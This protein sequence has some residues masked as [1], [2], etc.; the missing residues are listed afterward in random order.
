MLVL[1]SKIK[2]DDTTIPFV[3]MTRVARLRALNLMLNHARDAAHIR[4]LKPS[5]ARALSSP[6]ELE[7]ETGSS[8]PGDLQ[9]NRLCLPCGSRY[10]TS[11]QMMLKLAES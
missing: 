6:R 1:Q 9:K 2:C 7:R 11:F 10:L 3:T 5:L 4:A 8:P